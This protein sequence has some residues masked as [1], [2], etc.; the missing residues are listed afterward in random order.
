M[1]TPRT[2]CGRC[3]KCTGHIP[4]RAMLDELDIETLWIVWECATHS[5][6][7]ADDVQNIADAINA[8]WTPIA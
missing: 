2:R 5:S 6:Y 3:D 4:T 1:G 7:N 8:R